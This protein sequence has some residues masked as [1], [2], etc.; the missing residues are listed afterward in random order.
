MEQRIEKGDRTKLT[1][2]E[3]EEWI[4]ILLARLVEMNG[5]GHRHKGG[6]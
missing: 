5:P 3:L 6:D 4:A 2:K 1:K